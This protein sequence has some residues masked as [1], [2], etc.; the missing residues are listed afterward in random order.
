MAPTMSV[1]VDP[2]RTYVA[3]FLGLMVFTVLTV[4]A[5]AFDLGAATGM[6]FMNDVLAM[7][8]AV[9][10]ASLVVWFFMHVRHSTPLTRLVVVGS[11]L[12]L[13]FLVVLTLADYDTRGLLGV[14]GK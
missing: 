14:P 11:V 12:W 2:V 6:P 1:H 5:A 9:V 13:A 10:K 8:I 7:A 4:L 3:V